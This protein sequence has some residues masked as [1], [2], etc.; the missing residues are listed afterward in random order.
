MK[1]TFR[2]R[3]F[4]AL[5][6]CSALIAGCGGDGAVGD[7]S[8]SPRPQLASE[9]KVSEAANPASIVQSDFAAQIVANATRIK[10]AADPKA[11][12]ELVSYAASFH[13]VPMTPNTCSTLQSSLIPA[14]A[15]SYPVGGAVITS[16]SFVAADEPNNRNGD[17]CKLLGR[18]EPL[19][20]TGNIA[21]G[22]AT[23]NPP[24]IFEVNL[25]AKWNGAFVHYGGGG[26]DGTLSDG[27]TGVPGPSGLA[28]LNFAPSDAPTPLA[29]GFMTFG[30]DSGHQSGSI[31]SGTFAANDAAL[32]NYGR[33]QLKKT[34][35]AALYL[36]RNAYGVPRQLKG[37]YVGN[38]TGGRD[39]LSVAQNWPENYDAIFIN[40]PAHNYTGMRL[41]NIQ[42]GRL[43]WLNSA[44]SASPAGWINS[45]KTTVLMNAVMA[46]CDSLDGLEDGIISNVDACKAKADATL[47]SIRCTNG[48]DTGNSCLSDAQIATVKAIA[49]PMTFNYALANG[50]TRYGGYNIMAGMVFGGPAVTY[51]AN[52]A[53]NVPAYGSPYATRDFGPSATG[54]VLSSSGNYSTLFSNWCATASGGSA[55]N[56]PNAYHTGSEWMK[57][58]IARQTIN[59]DPRRLNPATGFYAGTPTTT[60][61]GTTFPG[62]PATSYVSRIVEVSNM[63]DATSTNLDAFIAKGGKIIWTHGSADEVVST[64][65]SIDYY[66]Q[67]VGKYG[68]AKVDSFVRFYIVYG[69]GHGDTGPFIPVFDSL[70][71]LSDWSVRNI[72]PGDSIV[73]GNKQTK[74]ALDPSPAGTAQRPMCRYPA[75]PKYVGGDPNLGSSFQC[76]AA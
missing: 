9:L 24:I 70:G 41:S 6:A 36:M 75:W 26:F 68:Q 17:F 31:T 21:L 49:S 32:A 15:F 45:Y 73:M 3:A 47:A 5:S 40:R 72:D 19:T 66:K 51:C 2:R 56:S 64:D 12:A 57:Y 52:P 65:S 29:R 8:V 7:N 1:Q 76:V 35:D 4:A 61:S 55:G 34:Q 28:P 22:S 54:P 27:S 48:V 30:S 67:L 62:T 23:T 13:P 63:T 74:S 16:A 43:L 38:S 25:P 39:G 44:G 14:T 20:P 18:I 10:D 53:N 50:V 33:L 69:N 46:A 58:F 11:A 37:Y 59:F 60:K 42:L 71:M